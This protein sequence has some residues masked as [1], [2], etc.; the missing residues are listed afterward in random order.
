MKLFAPET[1]NNLERLQHIK[2]I[3]GAE[4]REKL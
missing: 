4:I 1:D 3:I 2:D